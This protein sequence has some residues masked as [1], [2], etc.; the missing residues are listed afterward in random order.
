MSFQKHNSS[1]YPDHLLCE[2]DGLRH[3]QQQLSAI[4]S[5]IKTPQVISISKDTLELERIQAVGGSRSQWRQFGKALATLHQQQQ[6]RYGWYADNYIGLNPQI[7]MQTVDWG[8][9]FYQYRLLAQARMIIDQSRQQLV[10]QA[11]DACASQLIEFL[12][13]EVD[14]PALL[15]GDLWSGNVLFDQQHAWL[16][17]PAIYCGD[18]DADVAMTEL[19]GGFP[20]IFYQSYRSVRTISEQYPLKKVIYNLYHQLNHLNLFGDS[21]WPAVDRDL[22]TLHR[23]LAG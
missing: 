10:L 7:N 2:A 1:Q 17:D 18:A 11:M 22:R 15:H 21:Y 16:I 8:S 23:Q 6:P 3:L 9:F 19:F 12:D 5:P 4:N 14:H 13:K 20:G